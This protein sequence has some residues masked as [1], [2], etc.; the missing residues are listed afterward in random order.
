M[1]ALI[2]WAQ[3]QAHEVSWW[4]GDEIRTALMTCMTGLVAFTARM[5]WCL[6]DDM[7]DVKHDLHGIDGKNGIKSDV[8]LLVQRVDAIEDWKIASLAVSE[9]ERHHYH[10]PDRRAG[11]R[12]LGE[13]TDEGHRERMRRI[14]DDHPTHGE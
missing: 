10:G 11:P 9:S 8:R 4:S 12:R 6:R 1:I 3:Q 7:R 14:T 5:L 13:V 2:L